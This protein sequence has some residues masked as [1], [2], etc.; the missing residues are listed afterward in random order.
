MHANPVNSPSGEAA[1]G[2]FCCLGISLAARRR[3]TSAYAYSCRPAKHSLSL[4][5]RI[6]FL[7]SRALRKPRAGNTGP[8]AVAEMAERSRV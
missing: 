5:P 7:E 4:S 8:V 6:T 1:L 2:L 3:R